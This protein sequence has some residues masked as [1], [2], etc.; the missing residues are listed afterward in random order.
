M[1]S[2]AY[3]NKH[4]KQM[5]GVELIPPTA[6]VKSAVVLCPAQKHFCT[7]NPNTGEAL[8]SVCTLITDSGVTV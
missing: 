1:L 2:P 3:V 6:G 4:C 7:L 5:G 8:V